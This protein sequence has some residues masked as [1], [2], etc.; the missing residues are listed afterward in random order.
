MAIAR[1]RE[2]AREDSRRA[3]MLRLIEAMPLTSTG[4][5]A[6][7]PRGELMFPGMDIAKLMDRGVTFGACNVALTVY[8]GMRADALG[9]DKDTA[10]K[11][12]TAGLIPGFTLLP[13]GVW[14]VNRA[15]EHGCSYCYA[16]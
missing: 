11:E 3:Q 2:E 9:I 7:P 1:L 14:G 12:W 15:Q 8:S 10:K 13:S 5:V 6:T 4:F 16:S